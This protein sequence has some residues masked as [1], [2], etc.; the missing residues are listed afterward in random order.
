MKIGSRD[1][2]GLDDD[3]E[4]VGGTREVRSGVSSVLRDEDGSISNRPRLRRSL[5]SEAKIPSRN[6][7][8]CC[9]NCRALCEL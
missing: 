4:D 3:P 6:L 9:E 2:G 7:V 1:G 8:A 5:V